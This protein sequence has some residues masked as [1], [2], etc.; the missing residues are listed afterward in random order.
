MI[1]YILPLFV[2]M[3]VGCL[4]YDKCLDKCY[5]TTDFRM[6]IIDSVGNDLI[7][8]D[9][10]ILSLSD[11]SI[12]ASNGSEISLR[13]EFITKDNEVIIVEFDENF[14]RYSL[15]VNSVSIDS[16]TA[17]FY[18]VHEECCGKISYLD[19]VKFD[20]IE[21]FIPDPSF[22]ASTHLVVN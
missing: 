21:H 17:E 20:K 4:N 12:I 5:G 14:N 19:T 1:K 8:G 15:N 3:A 16:I 13:S 18:T 11:I 6:N 22:I 10:S 2:F 9:S 7:F